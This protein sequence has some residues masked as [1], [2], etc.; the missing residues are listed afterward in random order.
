METNTEEKLVLIAKRVKDKPKE[1]LTSLVHLLNAEYLKNCY[2]L[3]K[4]G[5][6]AG[7]DGRTTES[8]TDEE[9]NKVLIETARLIQTKGYNPKP[10]KRVY[11]NKEGGELR[12]LGIPTIVDKV[13]QLGVTRIL[14]TIWESEFLP[15]SYGYREGKDPHQCLKEI[16]HMI[17]GQKLNMCWI[18]GLR[19]K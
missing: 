12:P 16:N 6:A 2:K 1:K 3:L 17:M 5:K 7:I 10:V 4:R 15:V 11:I 19:E 9:I 18:C 13:V 8:Y 14:E